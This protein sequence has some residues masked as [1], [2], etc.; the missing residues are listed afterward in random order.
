MLTSGK[1]ELIVEGPKGRIRVN[2]GSLT[3]KPVEEIANSPS[4]RERLDDAVR[5]LY[6]GKPF[7]GHMQ[8]FF[9]CIADRDGVDVFTFEDSLIVDVGLTFSFVFRGEFFGPLAVDVAA[10]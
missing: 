5:K 8:N 10:S 1:N 3:G 4:E 9:D 6:R 2:R 7:G